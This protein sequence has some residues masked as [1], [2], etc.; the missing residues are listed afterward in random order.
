[1]TMR[2]KRPLRDQWWAL[3]GAGLTNP[4]FPS[5][6][7]SILFV[8]LGNICR[9][10]F[11][12]RRAEMRFAQAGNHRIRCASCGLRPSQATRPPSEACEVAAAYGVS[13]DN[14]AP[15]PL[16]SEL[17]LADLIV[18]M[19]ALQLQWVREAF[20]NHQN[21]LFLLSLLDADGRGAYERCNIADPF[22][23][24]LPAYADCYGRI[25]RALDKLVSTI[26]PPSTTSC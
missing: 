24:A 7:Q 8:C 23:Q 2:L 16:T 19:D 3:R 12:A 14:H 13:L 22:G 6:V 4:P 9:S 20:P 26:Q 18:V 17:M 15:Q 5:S 10:P 11:A 25:D 1:M 21:R